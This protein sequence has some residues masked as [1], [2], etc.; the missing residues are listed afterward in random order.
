MRKKPFRNALKKVGRKIYVDA[1]KFNSIL[2][3]LEAPAKAKGGR[4]R[5]T[6]SE[7]P[8]IAEGHSVIASG[9]PE[10]NNVDEKQQ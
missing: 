4:K 9:N 1:G 3:A 2:S 8:V 10:N 6:A 5:V 7:S